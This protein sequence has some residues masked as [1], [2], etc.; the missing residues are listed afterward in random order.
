M[1]VETRILVSAVVACAL[2]GVASAVGPASHNYDAVYTNNVPTID[3]V[4]SAGEWDDAANAGG[5]TILGGGGADSEANYFKAKWDNNG[6][7]FLH[8]TNYG[9]WVSPEGQAGHE[10]VKQYH[11]NINFFFDPNND[12]EAYKRPISQLDHYQLFFNQYMG[13]SEWDGE[14]IINTN[15]DSRA[16]INLPNGFGAQSLWTA[17][18]EDSRMKMINDEN[19]GIMEMFIKWTDFNTPNP[20]ENPPSHDLLVTG[21]P[22]AGTSWMFNCT[23]ISM[24]ENNELPVW[25]DTGGPS[26]IES[27]KNGWGSMTFVPEP[28]SLALF[29]LAG[30][31]LLRRRK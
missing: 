23:R 11:D 31:A 18:G 25:H 16:G 10:T 30:L 2:G 19:G 4:V 7:Y 8:G 24:D 21:A 9:S 27:N 14:N 20:G 28:A 12:G 15:M 26:F 1:R 3:G 29:G 6:I 22:E 17:L 5:W 13:E